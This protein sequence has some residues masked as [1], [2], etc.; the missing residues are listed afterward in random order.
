MSI[1][2]FICYKK[3]LSKEK[4]GRIVEQK[5]TEASILHYI[6][7]MDEELLFEPW[8]DDSELPTGV[9]WETEIY[10][11]ILES[12]VM[13]VLI[14]QGTSKSHWV[15]REIALATA[16]GISIIPLGFDLTFEE[17]DSEMK[18]LN[19]HHLQGKITHNIKLKN[20]KPLLSELSDDLVK[21][22]IRTKSEQEKTLG[23]LIA[24]RNP[25]ISKASDNQKA[26]TYFFDVNG[27]RFNIHIASGDISKVKGI[28][29]LVNSEN[30]YMQ[31]A[32]FFESKTVSSML[33]RRGARVRDGKYED[34]VQNELDWQLRDRGRPVQAAEAF[35]TSAGGLGSE[36]TSINKARYIIHVAA[37]QAVAAES[38]VIPYKQPYQIEACVRNCLL[39]MKDINNSKG[40]ISP[41]DSEQRKLQEL[42]VSEEKSEIK[43]IIFPLFGTGQGGS[44][45]KEVL[46]PMLSGLI[47]FLEDPDNKEL[48][49]V[50]D[51]IYIS[52]FKKQDIE[53]VK[54]IMQEKF[55]S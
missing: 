36:L 43:S 3:I 21:A 1:K 54:E 18:A 16:L 9:A 8:L 7:G 34:T 13:L 17:L 11:H 2:V 52:A 38:K 39:K 37:V 47:G 48:A 29:V 6:L 4:E 41:P 14:G 50:L 31:M 10:R 25:P 51:D 35:A 28:D 44:S 32:R 33:R 45:C 53:D 5:N 27:R 22:S 46:D 19:I 42:L 49:N 26:A 20:V 55:N 40:L 15:Q 24:R 23:S 30:D 12:D